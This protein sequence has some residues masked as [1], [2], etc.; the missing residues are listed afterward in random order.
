MQ[1]IVYTLKKDIAVTFEPAD[2]RAI[3]FAGA[4]LTSHGVIPIPEEYIDFLKITD[5]LV[6]NGMEL[7][8]TK[9]Y[10][11]ESKGYSLPGIIDANMDF[12][13]IDALAGKMILGRAS[14]E[15]LVYSGKDNRYQCVDR[16]DFMVTQVA[17]SF[18][19]LIYTF[20]EGLF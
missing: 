8:G 4:M 3:K 12:M 9:A 18:S 2:E 17:P 5:G 13:G 16:T 15:L 10:D 14:E 20:V 6:W 1:R 7:Y 11:R 19:E